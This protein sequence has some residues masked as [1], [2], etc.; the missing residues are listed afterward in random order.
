MRGWS[1][2]VAI[3]FARGST[4][5][6]M[7]G[8]LC[9]VC[10]ESDEASRYQCEAAAR[11]AKPGKRSALTVP[12]SDRIDASGNSSKTISTTGASRPTSTFVATWAS[13]SQISRLVDEKKRNDA[14]KTRGA[15]ARNRRPRRS[16]GQR[17]S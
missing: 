9:S 11:R 14:R 2:E 1:I 12:S 6:R 13:G 3:S 8:T 15:A 7:L 16:P 10:H 17:R 5:V 4:P